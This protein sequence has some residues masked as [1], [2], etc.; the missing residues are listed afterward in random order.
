LVIG[1]IESGANG[2]TVH[3]SVRGLRIANPNAEGGIAETIAHL[4]LAEES[5]ER[6]VTN[7][8]GRGIP[9][10][11]FEGGYAEWLEGTGGEGAF[12]I[13]VSEA[14]ETVEAILGGV[15]GRAT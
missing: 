8:S 1:R 10:E 15:L 7:L 2:N 5:L 13:T 4:A 12:S 9:D 3:I 11:Q 14:V 6:S